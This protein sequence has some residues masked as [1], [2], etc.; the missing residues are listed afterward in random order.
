M[1]S[2]TKDR[3]QSL[4]ERLATWSR[5]NSPWVIHYNSGS[6]NGCDIEILATFTPRYDVERFGIKLEGSPR[7]ADVLVCTGPVTVPAVASTE[8]IQP[9]AVNASTFVVTDAP[10]TNAGTPPLEALRSSATSR[11]TSLI[12]G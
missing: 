9:E 3:W 12:G 10:V 6:C 5:V 8:R 7:H 1:V 11:K 2:E 4:K